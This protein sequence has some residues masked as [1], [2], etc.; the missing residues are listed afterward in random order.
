MWREIKRKMRRL[1]ERSYLSRGR[2]REED[3]KGMEGVDGGKKDGKD[4]EEDLDGGEEGRG[5][6]RDM[7]GL[8]VERKKGSLKGYGRCGECFGR[9]N[10]WEDC[11]KS[12]RVE[13]KERVFIWER[14]SKRNLP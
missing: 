11:L 2:K 6:W 13:F 3:R 4:M 9:G 8:G 12:S 5:R 10:E 1:W 14:M 7:E